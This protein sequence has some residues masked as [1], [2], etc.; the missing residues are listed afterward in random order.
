MADKADC[1]AGEEEDEQGFF[2]VCGSFHLF[3][4]FEPVVLTFSRYRAHFSAK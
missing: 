3:L 2:H 4:P 1:E